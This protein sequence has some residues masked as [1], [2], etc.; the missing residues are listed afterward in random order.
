MTNHIL[1]IG[2][3]A[4]GLMAARILL[5][6]DHQVT[7]VEARDRV[8]G[9]IHTVP[10]M[11]SLPIEAGAEFMHG[12][13]PLTQELLNE[14]KSEVTLLSGN[15]YQLWDGVRGEGDYFDEHWDAFTRAL[16]KLK[17]DTDLASF[18]QEHFNDD[19]YKGMRKKVQAFVEGYD[20]ADLQRVSAMALGEEWAESD[21]EHQYHISGGYGRLMVYLQEKIRS[22][23]GVFHFSTPVEKIDWSPGKVMVHTHKNILHADKVI[24]TVPLG[25]LQQGTITFNPSLAAQSN[26]FREMGFGGVIKF[27]FEF[28]SAFWEECIPRPLKD[29]A[30][31][32]SDATIPT[33]WSQL[34]NRTPL[35]TGWLGGPS[36]HHLHH[37]AG[38]LYEK[39]IASLQYIFNCD[40]SDIREQIR[41][42]HIADWVKDPY[43]HGAYAYPT[44][45][46]SAAGACIVQPVRNTLYFAGEAFYHGPAMGTVEAALVSGKAVAEKIPAGND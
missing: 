20:A 30:F 5:E 33:W 24:I 43:A 41:Q 25:V 7:I 21:D 35:L 14:S 13:Q 12:Q 37:D 31:V 22:Q 3:G 18:L 42:W 27:F 23:G 15:R 44:V 36:T 32:F 10:S 8:G 6:K 19:K 45:R 29:I 1:I 40:A 34:P 4:A 11:F 28:K 2:A 46:G 38:E 16:G 17:H 9:R 26:A 39:A